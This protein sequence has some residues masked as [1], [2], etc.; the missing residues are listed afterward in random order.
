MTAIPHIATIKKIF[1]KRGVKFAYLFGSRA[2]NTAKTKGSDFDFAVF[3]QTGTPKTRFELRLKLMHELQEILAPSS[4]DLI[5]LN[6]TR[7][8]V[9]LDEVV[10][11]G[12][13][14]YEADTDARIEF[15]LRAMREYEEFAPFLRTYNK[16]YMS[17]ARV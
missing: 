14:L 9:L 16:M 13:L 5:L 17:S 6:D 3:L 15:E 4:V 11:A 8:V 1:A 10:R 12:N 7:S 2:A